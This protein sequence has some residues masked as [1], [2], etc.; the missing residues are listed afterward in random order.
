[1]AAAPKS[2]AA[3][4]ERDARDAAPQAGRPRAAPVVS[5]TPSHAPTPIPVRPAPT[6]IPVAA[7]SPPSQTTASS[8]PQS[9]E[10]GSVAVTGDA[11]LVRL[12]GPAGNFSPGAE[13][14]PGT[15]EITV[16]FGVTSM[17]AG[18]VTVRAGKS[19]TI[20]C[21]ASFMNCTAK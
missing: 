16:T 15:Y 4:V 10:T 14:P 5:P 20:N 18:R 3:A 21:V 1:M 13:I 6:R 11:D 2:P 8:A 9:A 12:S 19:A 17:E 7:P